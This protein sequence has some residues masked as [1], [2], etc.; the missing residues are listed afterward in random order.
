M[1]V[2]LLLFLILWPFAAAAQGFGGLGTDAEGFSDPEPGRV[3]SFPADHG[4]HPDYRI[5]WWYLTANLDAPD[6]SQYGLQWTL[7]RF[8]LAPDLP[9]GDERQIWMGHAA[10][11]TPQAHLSTERFARGGT[12]Q[13]GV[14][15]A[16][17]SA[18]IDDWEMTGPDFDRM[19]LRASAP[20]FAYDMTLVAEGPLV[21][22]GQD[23]YSVKSGDGQA[24][25]YYSQPFF[26]IEGELV[27]PDGEVAL[28]GHAWLDREWSSQPLSDD[29]DGWDWFSLVFDDGA[30]LMGFRLRGETDFTAASWIAPDGS[31][32]AYPDGA[33]AVEPLEEVRVAGRDVPVGWRVTLEDQGVDIR[34]DAVRQDAWMDVTVPY[35]EGPVSFEG[36]HSGRGYL[37]MTGY[38]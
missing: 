4:A 24:S 20:D 12:G 8:A 21:F 26:R 5:E 33:F 34:V 7:F 23:G 18:W 15:A 31:L 27:L 1:N 30:R 11:T 36:S 37:E 10:V 13:A 35:W 6:G 2:R 32:T 19:R 22:H 9:L 17:F 28:E 16:P 25:Y 3:F 14:Q 29:Q 38:E